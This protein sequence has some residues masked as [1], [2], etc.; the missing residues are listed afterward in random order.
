MAIGILADI[1]AYTQIFFLYFSWWVIPIGF[2]IYG[3]IKWGRYP[4]EAIILETRGDNIIKTNDRIGKMHDKSSGHTTYLIQKMGDVIDVLPFETILHCVSKPTNFLEYIINKLRPTIGTVHL[5]KYGSKQYKPVKIVRDKETH[6][7][8]FE[9]IKDKDGNDIVVNRVLPFDIRKHLGVIDFQII[10]WDDVNTTMNEIENS[11]MRRIAKWDS[12]SKFLLPIAIIAMAV[13]LS[14]VIIYL[15]YDAQ[16][17][18]CNAPQV[19]QL[20]GSGSASP[21]AINQSSILNAPIISQLTG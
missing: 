2:L 11:R 9:T 5:L 12:W 20:S 19:V 21:N 3:K 17:T 14:I 6:V 16:M 15:T 4:I 7:T 18:F 8:G 10:D 1:F 13:M